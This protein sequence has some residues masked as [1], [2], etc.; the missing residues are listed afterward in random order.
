MMLIA[1]LSFFCAALQFVAIT[2]YYVSLRL[3]KKKQQRTLNTTQLR[4]EDFRIIT[5]STATYEK[6]TGTLIKGITAEHV[7]V[8]ISYDS[9]TPEQAKAQHMGAV[10]HFF[11]VITDAYSRL[12]LPPI[13][14]QGCH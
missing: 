1:H 4:T 2:S 11:C 9:H 6:S 3:A 5:R 8:G 12:R 14:R 10:I 7:L 13:P